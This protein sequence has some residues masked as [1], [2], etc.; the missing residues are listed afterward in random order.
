VKARHRIF[1][2][3]IFIACFLLSGLAGQGQEGTKACPKPYIKTI[4]PHACRRGDLLTIRGEKF[5]RPCGEVLFSEAIHSPM[6]LLI[7][8]TAKAEILGW[9]FH[10]ISLIVPKSAA[11]GYLFIRVH[12]GKESNKVNF[13]VNE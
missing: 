6:D 3:T 5:G 4:F 9:T 2:L 11:T 8:P 10:R 1:V 13:T 7:A 12:C